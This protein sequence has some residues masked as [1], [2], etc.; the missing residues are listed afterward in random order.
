MVADTVRDE[1]R[2]YPRPIPAY[3]FLQ[4]PFNMAEAELDGVLWQISQPSDMAAIKNTTVSNGALYLYSILHLTVP[5]AETMAEWNEV[6]Q[7]E[8]P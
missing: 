2:I 7:A 1:S 5:H 3:S 6:G 8:N 4:P